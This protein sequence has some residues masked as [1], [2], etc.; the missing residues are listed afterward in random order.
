MFGDRESE[1][2]QNL[3]G[4]LTS[5]KMPDWYDPEFIDEKHTDNFNL[6]KEGL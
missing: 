3:K 4:T 2:F 5:V 1:I 6:L